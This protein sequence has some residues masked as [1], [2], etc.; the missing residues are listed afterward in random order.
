MHIPHFIFVYNFE[1][2]NNIRFTS[3]YSPIPRHTIKILF[4][5]TLDGMSDGFF[6]VTTTNVVIKL[7]GA[8]GS[9]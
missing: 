9:L 4:F 8:F 1:I 5:H 7:I 3:T 6:L 2:R